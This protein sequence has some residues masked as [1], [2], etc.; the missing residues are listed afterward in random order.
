M[1]S[2]AVFAAIHFQPLQFPGL[3]VFGLVAGTLVARTGRAGPAVWAHIGFNSTAA[4]SLY[5]S[6]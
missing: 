5:L 6:S 3:M 1:I 2:S 4:L